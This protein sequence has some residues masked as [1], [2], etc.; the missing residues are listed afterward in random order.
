MSHRIVIPMEQKIISFLHEQ[1]VLC[2]GAVLCAFVMGVKVGEGCR[3]GAWGF[4][5]TVK[6]M[7][8]KILFSFRYSFAVNI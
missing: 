3:R 6:F 5:V 7:F 8:T 2:P 1:I 4:S